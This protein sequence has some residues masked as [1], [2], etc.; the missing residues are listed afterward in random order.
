MDNEIIDLAGQLGVLLKTKGIKITTAESCTGGGIAQ[1]ITEISGSSAW[2]DR[3]FV[4]YSNHSKTQMLGV[5]QK[6][7]DEYGAVSSEVASEMVVGA[8]KNS[9]ANLAAAVTG[10]AGPDGG[11]QQKPVGTVYIAWQ[12]EGQDGHCVRKLFIGNKLRNLHCRHA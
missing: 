6:T 5:K 4:S 7:L 2:F 9:E 10:I 8:L 3:G 12:L 11:T 1:L